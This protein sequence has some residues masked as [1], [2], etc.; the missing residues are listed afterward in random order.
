MFKI[1]LRLI[2]KLLLKRVKYSES[3]LFI[4]D[5]WIKVLLTTPLGDKVMRIKFISLGLNS[6]MHYGH[7]VAVPTI[8]TQT[9]DKAVNYGAHT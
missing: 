3:L 5:E 6:P 9:N 4:L 2:D 8:K 7:V 1:I